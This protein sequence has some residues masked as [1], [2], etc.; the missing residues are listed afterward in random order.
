[1]TKYAEI[2]V[3]NINDFL[4]VFYARIRKD[5]VLGPIFDS[6]IGTSKQEWKEHVDIIGSFW[7]SVLLRT[8]TFKGNPMQTHLAITE[9]KEEHFTMWLAIFHKTAME[10]YTMDSANKFIEASN[11]MAFS[12]N[13]NICFHREMLEKQKYT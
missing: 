6:Y 1:M 4:T 9:I 10:Y 11:R 12:L 5:E 3:D 7:S 8:R 2:T 13:K